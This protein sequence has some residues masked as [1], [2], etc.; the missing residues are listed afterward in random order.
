[1]EEFRD[2]PGYEGFYQIS[3]LGNVISLV[4]LLPAAIETGRR[5]AKQSIMPGKNK[6][7]R[8]Q[9]TLCK[10]GFTK[11]FQVHRLVLLAFVGP[12]P[13]GMECRRLDGNHL[14]NRL[15]NLE[16]AT[17]AVNMSDML[18]HGTSVKGGKNFKAKLTEDDV[19]E[20]RTARATEREL[21]ARYGVSQVAVHFIRTR[22]T[23]KHVP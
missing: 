12:C 20:I 10:H 1:M 18:R 14:N 9:V 13:E 22:K 7:G 4:R 17:H 23:W 19:R 5:T 3:D 2:I 8:L 15:T 11:R 21:A 16:W 6:Q